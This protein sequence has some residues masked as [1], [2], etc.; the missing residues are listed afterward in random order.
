MSSPPE[1]D[2]NLWFY[3]SCRQPGCEGRHYLVGNPHTFPGR[4]LAICPASPWEWRAY[5]VSAQDVLE[6]C[7]EQARYWVAG[8]LNGGE[9][10]PPYDEEGDPLPRDH[11][12]VLRWVKEVRRFHETGVWV[13]GKPRHC[14]RCKELLLRSQP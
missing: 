2:P 9:P 6:R 10:W 1:H 11:P 12:D 7:S 3:D 13:V 5:N 14:R 8:F 4:M